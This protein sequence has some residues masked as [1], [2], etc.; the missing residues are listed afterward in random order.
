MPVLA[1]NR[2]LVKLPEAALDAVLLGTLPAT[3]IP[4]YP[5]ERSAAGTDSARTPEWFLHTPA[6]DDARRDE[7]PWDDAHAVAR[8]FRNAFSAESLATPYVEPDLLH[9]RYVRV[10]DSVER[11]AA[12]DTAWPALKGL[13]ADFSPYPHDQFALQ[14]HLER[15]RFPT[16]W[17][18]STGA[19]VRIAHLD[20]GYYPDHLST[21]RHMLREQGWNYFD[22]NGDTSDPGNELNAGHG[23]ATLALLA[24]KE[25]DLQYT[26]AGSTPAHTY[27]GVIGGAPDAEIVPVRIGGVFGS[28]VHLYSSSMAQ[29]LH[30][31]L[32]TPQRAPCDVVS[33]SHGG[34]PTKAWADEIN[35]LYDAGIVVAAAS[36]DSISAV[37]LDI[38]T[39]FTVYPSAWYRVITVTGETF[40]RGPYT[41]DHFGVM[42]GSWGPLKVMEKAVGAYTPNVPWMRLGNPRAWEMDGSGTSASTPQVAAACALWLAKYRSEL[43]ANWR[44]VAACRKLL[45]AGV[46]DPRLNVDKIGVGA[47]DAAGL[48][49]PVL[50]QAVVDDARLEEPTILQEIAPD[51]CSWPFFRLLFGLPP[52]GEGVDEMMEVEAQQLAYRS[53]N[54]RLQKAIQTYPDGVGLPAPLVRTLQSD[55]LN[56]PDMS[57]TLRIYLRQYVAGAAP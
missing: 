26:A 57:R 48:F 34:L 51:R 30:H 42:R 10:I 13:I 7:H 41:T 5:D 25:V 33:L 37:V 53:T 19:G 11:P 4:L 8:Q 24:G 56:E 16:A 15:A 22:A 38:A 12:D 49:D 36:G 3:T 20:T 32:G 39:H 28:V 29:G 45:F 54:P 40:S 14:W 50:S 2:F 47:L 43:P 18:S 1:A 44:R 9:R 55:F 52:P 21:P 27:A 6:L 46:A 31:A 35:R 17:L 23:T